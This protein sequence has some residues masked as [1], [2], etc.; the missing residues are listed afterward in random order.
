MLNLKNRNSKKYLILQSRPKSFRDCFITMGIGEDIKQAR[1]RSEWQKATVNML[2]THS[3]VNERIK[4]FLEQYDLSTQ[5]YNVLRIL[6]GSFPQPLSTQ[7]IRNRMLDKASDASRIVDR[8][9]VK[10]LVT[11]K[12]CK[13]DKRL[14]DVLIS[15]EGLKLLLVV[16]EKVDA[17]DENILQNLS[18][19]EAATLNELLDKIRK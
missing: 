9:I 1:F 18:E 4:N 5:Q 16:N 17:L 3:W 14:V 6:N 7:E 19:K 12:V 13:D 2:Y 11:K 15:D 8:L 10:G